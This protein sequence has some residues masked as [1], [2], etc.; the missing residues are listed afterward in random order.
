MNNQSNSSVACNTIP[1]PE[2]PICAFRCKAGSVSLKVV[3]K[4]GSV[5]FFT[6]S[7]NGT[8]IS[9]IPSDQI[10]FSVVAGQ[11]N[12]DIVYAFS[13]TVAGQGEL[14]EN[15][16]D[17]MLLDPNVSVTNPAVRYIICV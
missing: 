15:C 1:T 2:D 7:Y 6:A 16:K 10:T 11:H 8:A 13:D 4:T 9:G 17:S 3:G 14:H 5:E 12:L